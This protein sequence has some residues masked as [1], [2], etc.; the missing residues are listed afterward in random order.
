M[1]PTRSLSPTEN[2]FRWDP[3][4]FVA[5]PAAKPQSA[6]GVGAELTEDDLGD[7]DSPYPALIPKSERAAFRKGGWHVKALNGYEGRGEGASLPMQMGKTAFTL[8]LRGFPLAGDMLEFGTLKIGAQA[9]EVA[10]ES[11]GTRKLW[12]QTGWRE[13]PKAEYQTLAGRS[14]RKTNVPGLPWAWFVA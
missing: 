13:V 11:H 12:E 2:V 8:I 4:N 1:S 9:V 3:E 5:V 10:S 6:S 7:D 14:G